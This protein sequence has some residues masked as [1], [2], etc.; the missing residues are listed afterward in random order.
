MK[1]YREII[2]YDTFHFDDEYVV[3]TKV[4]KMCWGCE[5]KHKVGHMVWDASKFRRIFFC[6]DC[7]SK[8]NK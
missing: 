4:N 5:K 6:E 1:S 8:L 7:F 3:D 2:K